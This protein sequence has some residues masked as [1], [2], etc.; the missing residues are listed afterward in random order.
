[1]PTAESFNGG[2]G[3]GFPFCVTKVNVL[4]RGDGNPYFHYKVLTLSEVSILYWNTAY[5]V[6]S[7]SAPKDVEGTLSASL[8]HGD[9]L[10]EPDT[11]VCGGA[12]GIVRSDNDNFSSVRV[13]I[14]NPVPYR[15]YSGNTSNESNFI[16]YGISTVVSASVDYQLTEFWDIY[17]TGLM[18]YD[19]GP[20]G[21]PFTVTNVNVGGITISKLEAKDS[22]SEIEASISSLNFYTYV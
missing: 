6:A 17:Y 11:R 20:S 10:A 7:A 14:Q 13:I 1:M 3:N 4:D 15:L 22:V 9:T 18:A 19:N 16:G 21:T 2:K 12:D 8:T 5:A